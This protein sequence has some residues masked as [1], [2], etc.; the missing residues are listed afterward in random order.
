MK[1]DTHKCD[2][3]GTAVT[4][5]PAGWFSV[6]PLEVLSHDQKRWSHEGRIDLC[7]KCSALLGLPD[8]IDVRP[9][10]LLK[11]IRSLFRRDS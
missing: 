6:G 3:C 5:E 2:D 4:G 11:R 7:P 1:Y 8:I 9:L 10:A